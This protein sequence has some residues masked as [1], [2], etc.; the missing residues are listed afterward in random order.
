[1]HVKNL[2]L[3]CG[4]LYGSVSVGGTDPYDSGGELMPEQAA[5][6]VVFYDLDLSIDPDARHIQ[7]ALTVV[8]D[9]TDTLNWFVLDLDTVFRVD[10]V[11]DGGNNLTFHRDIGKLWIDLPTSVETPG[12]LTLVV[13]YQGHPR[14]AAFP[15]WRG[16]FVWSETDNGKPWIGVCC[17]SEGADIWWPCKDHPSD[18]PDSMALHFTVPQ[19]LQCVSNGRLREVVENP[20]A[21]RTWHWFVSLPINNYGVTVNIAEFTHIQKDDPAVGFPIHFWVLEDNLTEGD[22]LLAD[23]VEYL[24]FMQQYFGPYPFSN[25]KFGMVHTDYLGME[26]QTLISYGADFSENAFGFDELMLH[27]LSHEWWGNLVTAS[28]WKD[29]WLHEGFAMYTEALYAEHTGGR[30]A[31]FDYVRRFPT[32]N[33]YPVAPVDSRTIGSIYTNDVYYKAGLILHS[34]RYLIG[35]E[36]FF[37]LLREWVYP[38]TTLSDKDKCRLVSTEDF[39]SVAEQVTGLELNW[40]FHQYLRQA[41]LPVLEYRVR[42]DSLILAWQTN[43][44]LPF[45][46]PVEVRI[47]GIDHDVHMR[48]GRGTIWVGDTEFEID[49][50][51]WIL[52]QDII[53]MRVRDTNPARFELFNVYPNPFNS[54]VTAEY[55]LLKPGPVQL[56]F[57][58]IRGERILKLI[59]G[60]KA[61]GQH[62]VVYKAVDLP[63][64]AYFMRLITASYS[65]TA[66]ILLI[67]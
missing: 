65:R 32:Q 52:K 30:D 45:P 54:S 50:E 66:K 22:T 34:L 9:I 4:V 64:G 1:M 44:G 33:E 23:V 15:P 35:D 59:D 55:T 13:Y 7:G 39:I 17:Q 20:D 16:G 46:M 49:P 62:K 27:E 58:N 38:E 29:L 48:D 53:P 18:E 51:N 57:Y 40:F 67:R 43:S 24:K 41:D 37:T 5:Y 61:A 56:D 12:P 26:H 2:L 25:D 8:A 31:L 3:I 47:A 63:S 28:D 60:H 19:P 21:T 14:V 6:D 10:S 42:R 11:S 36:T